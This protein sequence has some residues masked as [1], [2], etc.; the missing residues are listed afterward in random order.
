MTTLVPQLIEETKHLLYGATHQRLNRISFNVDGFSQTISFLDEL[1]EITRGST[2]SVSDEIMY[3]LS[4]DQSAKTA[5]VYRGF[6]G[7]TAINH[8]S[9]ELVE[10]N[11]RFPRVFIKRALQQE[12]DS[13]G[14]RLFKVAPSNISFS[15]TS[16]IYD[17][18]ISNFISIIDVGF[19]PYSGRTTRSNA[20]RWSVLRDLDT[21]DY[22][23]GSAIEFLGNF[24]V[25]G[26]ARIKAA[27]KFDV[28]TWTDA[29]DVEAL[30]LSTSMM[31]IPPIGAAWR[32][33]S[34]KEVART[35][36]QAQPEPRR[37][38]EVPAG[39]IASVAAQ[40]KKLR[41]DRIEEER[42]TLM[43]RYPLKGVA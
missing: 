8:E 37:S 36:M 2:I 9:N 21:A 35:N 28:S 30:G 6:M 24:P 3:V 18:G 31:D 38:E 4:A 17:L 7:T 13:W 20:Y 39:H 1:N 12:I 16:R 32:L 34:T 27:Q 33:M 5:T 43:Q 26:T 25:S 15:Q 10:I 11:P 23:S 40:L 14:S 19:S 29:T 22:P 42:W 41:D